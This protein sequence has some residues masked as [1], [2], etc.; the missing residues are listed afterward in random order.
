MRAGGGGTAPCPLWG[1]WIRA[2]PLPL[3]P[4]GQKCLD[5]EQAEFAV[6]VGCCSRMAANAA[7]VLPLVF[8]FILYPP[9]TGDL[10]PHQGL[11]AV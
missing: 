7:Q 11:T 8:K 5:A 2:W 3:A 4:G 6:C 1:I 10:F 9:V